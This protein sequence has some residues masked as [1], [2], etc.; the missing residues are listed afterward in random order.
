[1]NKQEIAVELFDSGLNCSQSV[2]AAFAQDFGLEQKDACRFAAGFGGG[3]RIGS[4]CG[5][6]TGAFMVLG[7]KYGATE[8]SDKESK[9]KTYELVQLAAEK[10]KERFNTT[11]CAELLGFNLGTTQGL[12]RAKQ[13]G[14]FDRCGE[15]VAAAVEI[16]ESMLNE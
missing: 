2:V 12:V 13:P 6:L 4:T 3:M 5:A 16:L 14:S 8:P 7:L 9:A 15:Y 10:F 1:M 11:S